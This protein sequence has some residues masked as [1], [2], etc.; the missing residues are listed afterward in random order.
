MTTS[1]DAAGGGAAGGKPQRTFSLI[2]PVFFNAETLPALFVALRAFEAELAGLGLR[3]ELIFVDDGSRDA[4]FDQLMGFRASREGTKVVRLSRNFGAPAA[5][6]AGMRFVTGDCFMFF[7]ADLQEPLEQVLLMVQQWIAGR[8]LVLSTRRSRGDPAATRAFAALFRTL[9]R[10]FVRSDFPHGGIGLVLMDRVM[11]QPMLNST[12]N[13]NP[14]VYAFWLGFDP[15]ILEYDRAARPSGR[16]RWTFGKKF[17]YMID[18]LT[19]FSV[20]PI[21]VMSAIGLVTAIISFAYAVRIVIA[22][23]AGEIAVSGFA[24][25]VTVNAFLGGCMLFMLGVIGEYLWR[26]FDQV[27][28]RPEAVVAEEHL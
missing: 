11:L 26:T 24:T 25:I 2:I 15:A 23:L 13:I 8:K 10:F 17:Q 28:G 9:V 5:V 4:S 3:L 18:T 19:G 21:R 1:P 27:S 14:N 7:A 12:K 16:S 22:A 6:K 20:V